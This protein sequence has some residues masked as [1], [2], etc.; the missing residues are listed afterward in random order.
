MCFSIVP[1]LLTHVKSAHNL[2]LY[3]ISFPRNMF[4]C[5]RLGTVEIIYKIVL[6]P[7]WFQFSH[8]RMK[9]HM[10]YILLPR[11]RIVMSWL[12]F[13]LWFLSP[14]DH[15]TSMNK[16]VDCYYEICLNLRNC[17]K[18]LGF[19]PFLFIRPLFNKRFFWKVNC[20]KVH[21]PKI[22]SEGYAA[23]WH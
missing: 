4:I 18:I 5:I 6:Y 12:G 10:E 3:T 22:I 7:S 15:N 23:D 9:W 16:K 14:L 8:H 17:G 20:C 2:C 11:Q 19:L 21:V 13:D 1:L